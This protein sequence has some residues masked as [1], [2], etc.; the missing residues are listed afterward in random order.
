[1]KSKQF[2]VA[3]KC[4]DG[5]KLVHSKEEPVN[6]AAE[7]LTGEEKE[8]SIPTFQV[9]DPCDEKSSVFNSRSTRLLLRSFS[10]MLS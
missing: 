9:Q 2:P 8:L 10:Y 3:N 4:F 5:G 7:K 1:M 6:R